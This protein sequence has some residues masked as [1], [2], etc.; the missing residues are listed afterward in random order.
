M[1]TDLSSTCV[2]SYAFLRYSGWFSSDLAGNHVSAH[3]NESSCAS[4]QRL[5]HELS[6][7]A[8]KFS[9]HFSLMEN[10]LFNEHLE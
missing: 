3:V 9:Y 1:P 2:R 7:Q 5:G 4:A 10:A 8:F 6:R